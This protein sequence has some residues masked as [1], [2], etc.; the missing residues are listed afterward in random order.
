MSVKD[1]VAKLKPLNILLYPHS[2]VSGEHQKS[3][4]VIYYLNKETKHFYTQATFTDAAQGPPKHVHGGVTAA[5]FDEALGG[6]AWFNGYPVLTAQL[7]LTFKVP[8]NIKTKIFVD[9][10]IDSIE[11]KKIYLRGVMVDSDDIIYAEATGIYLFQDIEIF[12]KMGNL[13]DDYFNKV[14]NYIGINFHSIKA[15]K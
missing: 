1:E 15:N 10:W 11:R 9:S 14:K 12:K 3:F 6:A 7:N 4:K 2:F 5:I 8:I 13:S